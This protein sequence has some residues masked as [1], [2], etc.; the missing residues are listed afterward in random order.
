MK[1]K[2]S[3]F[4]SNQGFE[5]KKLGLYLA[6]ILTIF[7]L[8]LPI[9][10]SKLEKQDET[11][12]KS[13]EGTLT[14]KANKMKEERAQ[15]QNEPAP[16][17][18]KKIDNDAQIK[19]VTTVPK[20]QKP[21]E[22][23][24][25]EKSETKLL[26]EKSTATKVTMQEETK[27]SIVNIDEI[28]WPAKG[29]V[30]RGYGLSYSKTYEDYRFHNGV[31]LKLVEGEIIKAALPGEVISV[32]NTEGEGVVITINHGDRWQTVYSQLGS[33]QVKTGEKVTQ[34]QNIG[35]IGKPGFTEVVEGIHLH[36]ALKKQD[37][38]VNPLDYLK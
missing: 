9:I 19:Q 13:E 31:D 37:Q 2:L 16:K 18:T 15:V 7:V 26:T 8:C 23:A 27:K 24:P 20:Q 29:N 36:F 25:Q 6:V 30:D 21:E 35:T 14:A 17:N 4:F 10:G 32:L 28:T 5:L 33:S 38:Y 3:E 22:S 11:K 12:P 34:G 1:E